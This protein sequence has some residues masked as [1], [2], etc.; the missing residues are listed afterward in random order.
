ML[1]AA[2]H[3]EAAAG[4]TTRLELC[5]LRPT[6]LDQESHLEGEG[7][8]QSRLGSPCSALGRSRRQ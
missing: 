3:L 7:S 8:A 2:N 1:T 5:Y 6:L 4:P